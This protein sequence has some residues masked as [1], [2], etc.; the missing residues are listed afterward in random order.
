[1]LVNQSMAVSQQYGMAIEKT[2]VILGAIRLNASNRY[3]E[4]LCFPKQSFLY[5]QF[6]PLLCNKD[7]KLIILHSS[8][9]EGG[10]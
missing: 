1:M 8:L 2:N 10:N 5:V 6:Y 4:V 3:Q 7:I 9:A